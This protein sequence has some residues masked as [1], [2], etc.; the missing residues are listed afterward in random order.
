MRRKSLRK[1]CNA[2]HTNYVL[3]QI[4]SCESKTFVH[5][6][7]WMHG[8]HF[9]C[10]SHKSTYFLSWC[11]PIVFIVAVHFFQM[12]FIEMFILQRAFTK[13]AQ[14]LICTCFDCVLASMCKYICGKFCPTTDHFSIS[15]HSLWLAWSFSTA[16]IIYVHCIDVDWT[17][18]C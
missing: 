11:V 6:D 9:D 4:G 5:M 17:L 18:A 13:N 15:I 10:W 16:C 7:A 1:E 2:M 12:L 14:N 3:W 8:I